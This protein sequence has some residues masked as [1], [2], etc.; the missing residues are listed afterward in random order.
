MAVLA[1]IVVFVGV[2]C[3]LDLILTVGVIKRLR[4]HTEILSRQNTMDSAGIA[5]GEQVGEF[6]V[7]TVEGDLVGRDS[8]TGETLVGFFSPG[9]KPCQERLPKFVE[10][11]R[12][13][14]GGRDRVLATAVGSA[15]STAEFV[16]ALTPVARVVVETADGPVGAAFRIQALPSVLMV[17]PDGDGRPVVTDNR[18][19]LNRPAVAV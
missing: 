12:A 11:A 5:V 19:D 15:E 1:A 2:L 14:P 6:A 13:M 9:C 16:A 18:V 10:Y 7:P 3:V 17:A 8:L 4:E